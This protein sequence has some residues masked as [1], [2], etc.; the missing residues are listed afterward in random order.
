MQRRSPDL[1][2]REAQDAEGLG[3]KAIMG[4][5]GVVGDG[6]LWRDRTREARRPARV[7]G[8]RFTTAQ[9]SEHS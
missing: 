2:E 1:R 6:R 9:E 4:G 7:Q 8:V 3:A 5:S